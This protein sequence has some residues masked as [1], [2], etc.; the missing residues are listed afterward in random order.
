MENSYKQ[1]SDQ[2]TVLT[3]TSRQIEAL[4]L[5][6]GNL[7]TLVSN[8]DEVDMISPTTYDCELFFA[9]LRELCHHDNTVESVMHAIKNQFTIKNL[10]SEFKL[11]YNTAR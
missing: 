5:Y 4:I 11:K 9:S 1:T 7:L 2:G 8:N 10:L 6:V 3:F